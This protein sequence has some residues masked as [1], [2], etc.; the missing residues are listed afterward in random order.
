MST[1]DADPRDARSGRQSVVSNGPHVSFWIREL[2]FSLVLILTL[3]GVA[4]SSLLKQPIMGYWELLGAG[5][6]ISLCRL[7]MVQ[8]QRQKHANAIDSHAGAA[9]G[10][11]P[12]CDEY[13][14]VAWR[15]GDSQFQCD[16]ARRSHVIGARHLYS[17]CS[18]PFLADL[19]SRDHHGALRSGGGV[20]RSFSSDCRVDFD[21]GNGTRR[22]ALVALAREPSPESLSERADQAST[23]D[24]MC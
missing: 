8:R 23:F 7:R 5:D 17:R 19:S 16:R 2:P 14:A 3:L 11:V 18:Y 20:D 9:L 12:A 6:R 13:D 24:S 15:P 21:G 4:Y 1:M 22:C 10:G